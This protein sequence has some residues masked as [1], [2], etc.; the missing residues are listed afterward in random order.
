MA[1]AAACAIHADEI[2][3]A[4]VWLVNRAITIV[5]D[6][7]ANLGRGTH[8]ALAYDLAR[9][10]R[11]R[12]GQTRRLVLGRDGSIACFADLRIVRADFGLFIDATI[13]VVV[14]AIADFEAGR[15]CGTNEAH[16]RLAFEHARTTSRQSTDQTDAGDV[17]D[18]TIAVVIDSVASFRTRADAAVTNHLRARAGIYA[19]GAYALT[20]LGAI[21]ATGIA[22]DIAIAIVDLVV[23]EAIAI[24]IEAV[25]QFGRRNNFANAGAPH[26]RAA[27]RRRCALLRSSVTNAHTFGIHRPTVTRLRHA[28]DDAVAIVV[29][30]IARFGDGTDAAGALQ[31]AIDAR[32]GTRF[33][34]TQ[35]DAARLANVDGIVIRN[36]VAVVVHA[37]AH[38]GRRDA[39]LTNAVFVDQ[40][41]AVVIESIADFRRR[42]LPRHRDLA[43]RTILGCIAD[44]N[45]RAFA[46]AFQPIITRSALVRKVLV[47]EGIALVVEVVALFEDGGRSND[48]GEG[49]GQR[50]LVVGK[51]RRARAARCGNGIELRRFRGQGAEANDVG[52]DGRSGNRGTKS[53]SS[54][55]W[56]ALATLRAVRQENGRVFATRH[57][58]VAL[59]DRLQI[60]SRR[61]E[62]PSQRR[63]PRSS[64]LAIAA[65]HER[66]MIAGK[67]AGIEHRLLPIEPLERLLQGF[68]E[69]DHE[70]GPTARRSARTGVIYAIVLIGPTNVDVGIERGRVSRCVNHL[71]VAS[72]CRIGR[73]DVVAGIV[74]AAANLLAFE[75]ARRLTTAIVRHVLM[76]AANGE[77]SI[78]ESREHVAQGL[79][80]NEEARVIPIDHVRVTRSVHAD[81]TRRSVAVR[82]FAIDVVQHRA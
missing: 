48:R 43:G 15:G 57:C 47:D 5:V 64:Q 24:V 59:N 29:E 53:R 19:V 37:V 30:A 80:R 23:D 56:I 2:A 49:I 13:A 31:D 71:Q 58:A 33:A 16:A 78:G 74:V 76:V 18:L 79:L 1:F 21:S 67:D 42:H 51:I 61:V 54:R 75:P 22:R 73:G 9:F 60:I 17:V 68:A 38:F 45:A 34:N 10:A 72:Q 46:N 32:R 55:N 39:L 66:A 69:A 63:G 25:T 35:V 44:E 20:A 27:S 70:I 3:R 26:G 36:G 52:V 14:D 11:G 62:R 77:I 40:T 65:A 8:G 81:V 7:V 41:I 50:I 6:A 28:I 82:R 12:S 4:G